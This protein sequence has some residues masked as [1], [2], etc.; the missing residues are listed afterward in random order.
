M[1]GKKESGIIVLKRLIKTPAIIAFIG[2]MIIFL[3]GISM[4]D[5]LVGAIGAE[6]PSPCVIILRCL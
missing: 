6:E 5:T 2:G 1:F 4:P 3:F